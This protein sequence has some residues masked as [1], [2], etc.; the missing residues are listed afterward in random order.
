MIGVGRRG[1]QLM[2]MPAEGRIVAVCDLNRL[3]AD[4]V[5]RSRKCRPEYDYRTMLEAKDVDAVVIAT[6]DHWH[7]LASIHA[8][9]AGKDVYTEKPLSLTVPRGPGDGPG[10]AQVRPRVSN[11]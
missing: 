2:S 3:R 1:L 4:S 10:C 11:R 7:A 5:A 9:Q 8:C 6:P